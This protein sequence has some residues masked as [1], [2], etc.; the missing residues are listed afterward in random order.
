MPHSG[1]EEQSPWSAF[2]ADNGPLQ[3]TGADRGRLLDNT[4]TLGGTAWYPLSGR[5]NYSSG[6]P[7]FGTGYCYTS[8]ALSG[9]AY[10]LGIYTG[11]INAWAGATLNG[12]AEGFPVRCIRE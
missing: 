10:Y 6:S 4:V 3:G 1:A 7:F 8:T 5:R 12:R 2:T 11:H 9:K